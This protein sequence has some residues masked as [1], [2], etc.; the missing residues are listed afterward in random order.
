M[1]WPE[2]ASLRMRTMR[3]TRPAARPVAV[4]GWATS[5]C[6]GRRSESV[7]GEIVGAWIY[8]ARVG[9]SDED[10]QHH[11]TFVHEGERRFI[12][13]ARRDGARGLVLLPEGAAQAQRAPTKSELMCPVPGCPMPDLTTVDRSRAGRRDGY[14]HLAKGVDHGAERMHHVLAKGLLA[15]WA[16]WAMPG[17]TAIEEHPSN[18]ARERIADVMVRLPDGAQFAL[19]VQYSSLSVEAWRERHES[20]RR[21]GIVDVWLFGHAGEQSRWRGGVM[22]LNATQREIAASGAPVLWINPLTEEVAYATSTAWSSG[23]ATILAQEEGQLRVVPLAQ[24]RLLED[25]MFTRELVELRDATVA[26]LA[27]EAAASARRAADEAARQALRDQIVGARERDHEAWLASSERAAAMAALGEWPTWLAGEDPV[28]VRVS[29]ERWRW[30]LWSEVI[31]PIAK[32]EHVRSTDLLADLL[33]RF[34]DAVGGVTPDAPGGPLRAAVIAMLNA[35]RRPSLVSRHEQ[36]RFGVKH[37]WFT[38]GSVREPLTPGQRSEVTRRASEREARLAGGSG[39]TTSSADY[40]RGPGAFTGSSRRLLS[41]M[42]PVPS[43][44]RGPGPGE[45]ACARCGLPVATFLVEQGL[46]THPVCSR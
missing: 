45:R 40:R 8:D 27:R 30:F 25:G 34:G 10:T 39:S 14:R 31:R 6:I 23:R 46:L 26:H 21:N 20:Y 33:T 37:F 17:A 18:D 15:R 38:R 44:S 24:W 41:G 12:Y 4:D 7:T 19:E 42:P 11:A 16:R 1:K 22:H 28:G 5:G 35:M 3:V 36:K 29:G 9:M 43:I 13:A 2:A 32:D